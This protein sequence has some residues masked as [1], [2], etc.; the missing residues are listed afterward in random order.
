MSTTP[1]W[2]N[3]PPSNHNQRILWIVNLMDIY[4]K[5]WN[6]YCGTTITLYCMVGI[7]QWES[8]NLTWIW[9]CLCEYS[10]RAAGH[11][12]VVACAY[13]TLWTVNPDFIF[14]LG[15]FLLWVSLW[16]PHQALFRTHLNIIYIMQL[17]KID[18]KSGV[19]S[20]LF[21]GRG[22]TA[23]TNDCMESRRCIPVCARTMTVHGYFIR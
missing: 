12:N 19:M 16:H 21:N 4:Q 6:Y 1:F 2:Q 9:W 11:W 15:P 20:C 3:Q 13:F 17:Q 18:E 14:T 8:H 5:N 22:Q 7:L 23:L 10:H